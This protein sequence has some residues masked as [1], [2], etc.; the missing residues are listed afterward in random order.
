HCPST[1]SNLMFA[2]LKDCTAQIVGNKR[3]AY[4]SCF[5]GAEASLVYSYTKFGI[6]Q[7][8]I[9]Y[10]KCPPPSAFGMDDD[11]THLLMITEFT[12]FPTPQ[13]QEQSWPAGLETLTDQTVDFSSMQLV[14]G[15]AALTSNDNIRQGIPVAKTWAVLNG[16][17]VLIDRIQFHYVRDA[18]MQLPDEDNPTNSPS[19]IITN[20]SISAATR[21]LAKTTPRIL[22]RSTESVH[23]RWVSA[24]MLI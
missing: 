22:H 1:G 18:L 8:L 7:D 9:F 12:S 13:I 23:A 14:P 16:R 21:Y 19:G 10:G 2:V 17:T 4:L 15:R 3:V 11:R 6:S 5:D 24:E 20:A